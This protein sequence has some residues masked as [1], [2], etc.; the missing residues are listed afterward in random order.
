[1]YT[2]TG[3]ETNDVWQLYVNDSLHTSNSGGSQGPNGFNINNQYSQF[4]SAQVAMV[5]CW[6]RVLT[7]TEI[8][9]VF[10]VYRKRFGI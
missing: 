7:A 8:S 3:D 6:D 4:S 10:E 1:M 9:Q 2:G 5:A